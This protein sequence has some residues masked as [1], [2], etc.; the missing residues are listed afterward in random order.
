MGRQTN[1]TFAVTYLYICQPIYLCSCKLHA[2]SSEGT[3][4]W[5]R[6]LSGNSFICGRCSEVST[7]KL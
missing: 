3:D 1:L 7:Y 4:F 6:S 5:Q 2:Y